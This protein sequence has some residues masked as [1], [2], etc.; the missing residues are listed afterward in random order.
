T[1]SVVS[2]QY[3]DQIPD[4]AALDKM[5]LPTVTVDD[6]LDRRHLATAHEIFDGIL[7]VRLVGPAWGYSL[8]GG[9]WDQITCLRSAERVLYD[10]ADRPDFCHRLI[11]HFVRRM[12]HIVDQYEALGLFDVDA[13]LVHC[14][15]AYTDEL[16]AA[17]YDGKIARAKDVWI[18]GLGQVFSTV[19][20]A[21]HDEFEIQPARPLLERFGLCYYGCCDPLDRKIHIVRQ[22]KNVRKI[23]ISPWADAERAA[24]QIAA[25]YVF[26]AKPNPALLATDQFDEELVRK[27]LTHIVATCRQY[28][29]PCELILKDV[30]TV[31][32]QPER[33]TAWDRIAKEIVAEAA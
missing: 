22:I 31:R 13:P 33:L 16:P 28:R 10:L 7:D 18:F 12:S 23:S 4:D 11:N 25:D 29:T 1:N 2:H 6:A 32:H 14:T 3:A 17:D 21:M 19:S 26:S 27:E 8:H 5:A 30:S 20:P 15:G 9:M 24:S